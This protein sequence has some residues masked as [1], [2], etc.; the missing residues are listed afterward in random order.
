MNTKDLLK[1]L[2][3]IVFLASLVSCKPAQ[4]PQTVGVADSTI[5]TYVPPSEYNTDDVYS[6]DSNNFASDDTTEE[7]DF[8]LKNPLLSLIHI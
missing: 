8:S 5:P 1:Y 7:E 4:E 2:L 3:P 6:A